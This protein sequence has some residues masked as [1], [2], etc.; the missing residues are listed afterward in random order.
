MK[1]SDLKSSASSQVSQ[2]HNDSLH[3][4]YRQ[5]L[6]NNQEIYSNTHLKRYKTFVGD[7]KYTR[8]FQEVLKSL[9]FVDRLTKDLLRQMFF[10]SRSEVQNLDSDILTEEEF[11]EIFDWKRQPS[12][13]LQSFV[14]NEKE[15]DCD[16]FHILF[17]SLLQIE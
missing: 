9:T 13:L 10:R 14:E 12:H 7:W 4:F 1:T 11:E 5:R 16:N 2:D 17:S 15:I 8:S 6:L 3:Q